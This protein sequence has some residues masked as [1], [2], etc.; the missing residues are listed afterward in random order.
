VGPPSPRRLPENRPAPF[1]P[2]RDGGEVIFPGGPP[3]PRSVAACLSV[4]W[5]R[6][7]GEQCPP[8]ILGMGRTQVSPLLFQRNLCY[9]AFHKAIWLKK[10]K[11]VGGLTWLDGSKNPFF[12]LWGQSCRII[13]V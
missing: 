5:K 10:R 1:P 13:S 11:L 12:R 2:D 6:N 7:E 9:H 8:Y 4:A 3:A